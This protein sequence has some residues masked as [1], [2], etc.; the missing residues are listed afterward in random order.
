MH[1]LGGLVVV[2]GCHEA[3]VA[4]ELVEGERSELESQ[5]GTLLFQGDSSTTSKRL[6]CLFSHLLPSRGCEHDPL[7]ISGISTSLEKGMDGAFEATKEVVVQSWIFFLLL[8]ASARNYAR[9]ISPQR[10]G[11]FRLKR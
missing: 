9:C 5:G 3:P 10:K 8:F 1:K 2:G 7:P 11:A 6:F 4:G